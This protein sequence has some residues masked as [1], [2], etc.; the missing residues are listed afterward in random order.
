MLLIDDDADQRLLTERALVKALP[1]GSSVHLT[2]SGNDA[3]SYM[4]GEGVY[5]DRSAYPFPTLVITDLNMPDGDGFDVLEFL[6]QNPEW[7]VVPRIMFS[8]SDNDDDVRTAFGLG[9]SAYHIKP[10]GNEKLAECMRSILEYWASCEVPPIDEAGRLLITNS[11]GRLG[12][13]YPQAKGAPAMKRPNQEA[14]EKDEV[15]ATRLL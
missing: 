15:L 12:A 4:I 2:R 13:R 3:I 1:T 5:S 7:S 9:V 11:K 8:S 6:Q 14:N 10:A